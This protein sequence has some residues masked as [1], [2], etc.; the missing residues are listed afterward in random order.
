MY[1]NHVTK[2]S[3]FSHLYIFTIIILFT[4]TMHRLLRILLFV[5]L[6]CNFEFASNVRSAHAHVMVTN[7]TQNLEIRILFPVHGLQIST[8]PSKTNFNEFFYFLVL[9]LKNQA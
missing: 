6:L 2:I 7:L 3:L 1:V 8:E 5:S 4:Y 9:E